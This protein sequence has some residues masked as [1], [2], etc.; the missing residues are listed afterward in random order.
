MFGR[1]ERNKKTTNLQCKD[2]DADT[3]VVLI[4][5]EKPAAAP[6]LQGVREVSACAAHPWH[7]AEA[8]P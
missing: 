3:G 1:K 6:V 5:G 8:L 7:Q 2:A 4:P